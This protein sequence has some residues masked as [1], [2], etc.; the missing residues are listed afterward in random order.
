MPLLNIHL[1]LF[2]LDLKQYFGYKLLN[3]PMPNH[4]K[5]CGSLR[6]FH[7]MDS[8]VVVGERGLYVCQT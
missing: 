8:T 4:L 5:V 6:G 3:T 2:V 1:S 7:A